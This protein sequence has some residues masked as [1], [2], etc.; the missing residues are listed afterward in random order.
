MPEVKMRVSVN[1]DLDIPAIDVFGMTVLVDG[2]DVS[3]RCVEADN[4]SACVLCLVLD[5][6]GNS[7]LDETTREPVTETLSGRVQI[8]DKDG[9]EL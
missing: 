5:D 2:K 4:I 9:V 6:N 1:R 8:F 7:F 3:D